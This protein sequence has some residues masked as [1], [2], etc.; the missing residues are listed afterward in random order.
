MGRPSP[1]EA[2]GWD[3]G[4]KAAC[5]AGSAS[6]QRIDKHDPYQA[7]HG[8]WVRAMPSNRARQRNPIGGIPIVVVSFPGVRGKQ[9]WVAMVPLKEMV[10]EV[11]K[12]IPADAVVE[13]SNSICLRSGR[14]SSVKRID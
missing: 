3:L 11:R 13:L 8:K 2:E 9:W 5:R 1:R 7:R 14:L 6:D 12:R 4:R 10:S